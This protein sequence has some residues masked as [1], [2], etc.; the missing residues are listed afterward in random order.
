MSSDESASDSSASEAE[1]DNE[2][3]QTEESSAPPKK[4]MLIT[5][6]LPWRSEHLEE[7]LKN[8]D[9][10]SQRKRSARASSMLLKRRGTEIASARLAPIDAQSV[11]VRGSVSED[12]LLKFSKQGTFIFNKQILKA[13]VTLFHFKIKHAGSMKEI[14]IVLKLGKTVRLT[15]NHCLKISSIC[16][17]L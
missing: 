7:T 11:T 10:K 5:K 3:S 12:D 17:F 8:L 15:V 2:D 13:A 16:S 14:E 4:K 1:H 9:K 6:K